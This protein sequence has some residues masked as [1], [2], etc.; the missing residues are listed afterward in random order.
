LARVTGASLVY[1]PHELETETYTM[2]GVKK[3]AAKLIEKALVRRCSLV[4]AVNEPIAQWYAERYRISKPVV[5]G[6]VPVVRDAE[7][8]LRRRLGIPPEEMLYVHTG[9]LVGGRNIPRILDAFSRSPH[10][11]LF[12]G[13]G[14]LRADVVAAGAAHPRIRW[15]PP[16]DPDLIVA[17]MREADVGL[18]LIES[19]LDLSKQLSSPN[20][21]TE[22]LA[23]GTP[24]LCTDLI[25]ARRVLGALSETWVLHDIDELE[26][27]LKRISH[28]D[29]AAFRASWS[30]VP[31]WSDEVRPLVDAYRDVVGMAHDSPDTHNCR[32]E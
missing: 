12:L 13:D 27:A 14:P 20:K 4:S 18:C 24:A 7:V 19:E 16:V 31:E 11:V 1:N 28:A 8:G 17:H 30:G 29:V 2:R 32:S 26:D 21:L 15:M 6:N 3:A 25:E 5:V 10:H 23:A 9:H 22:A